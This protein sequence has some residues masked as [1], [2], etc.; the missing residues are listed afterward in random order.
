RLGL[1]LA[2]VRHVGVRKGAGFTLADGLSDSQEDHSVYSRERRRRRAAAGRRAAT[3]FDRLRQTTN[4][5]ESV[6]EY[7]AIACATPS[8]DEV[9]ADAAIMSVLYQLEDDTVDSRAD[10]GWLFGGLL[11]GAAGV[12]ARRAAKSRKVPTRPLPATPRYSGQTL[13][14]AD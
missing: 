13:K 9:F 11:A 14:L 8:C 4:P 5:L 10:R 3:T 2:T 1:L 6:D 7:N 12:A